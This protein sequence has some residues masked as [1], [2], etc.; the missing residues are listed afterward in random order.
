MVQDED[1]E[2]VE[3]EF[4]DEGAMEAMEAVLEKIEWEQVLASVGQMLDTV[5][6]AIMEGLLEGKTQKEVGLMLG[7]SQSAVSQ[8]WARICALVRQVAG[9]LG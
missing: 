4:V 1:G 6:W 7:I 8:R 5:D 2:E 9:D 3:R